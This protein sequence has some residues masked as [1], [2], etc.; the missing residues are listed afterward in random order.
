MGK[1]GGCVL[2]E[3]GGIWSNQF[4]SFPLSVCWLIGALKKAR[5]KT[6]LSFQEHCLLLG[7][8]KEYILS[9]LRPL[10]KGSR[11]FPLNS[12]I[13][14]QNMAF[15][16]E[17]WFREKRASQ[18]TCLYFGWLKK[19]NF[20]ILKSFSPKKGHAKPRTSQAKILQ[21]KSGTNHP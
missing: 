12:N 14:S 13:Y 10:E 21:Q 18:G 6:I 7:G 1:Q 5:R 16:T 4:C 17:L 8:V 20:W 11:N 2:S 15:S 19:D 3:W 9:T